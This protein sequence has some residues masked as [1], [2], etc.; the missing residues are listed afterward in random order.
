MVALR[1]RVMQAHAKRRAIGIA[2][3]KAEPAQK[4]PL[5][6]RVQLVREGHIHRPAHTSIPTLFGPLRAGGKFAWRHGGTDDLPF[7]D[8]R[9]VLRPIVLFASALVGQF[10]ARVVGNLRDSTVAF[11]PADRANGKMEYRHVSNRGFGLVGKKDRCPARGSEPPP[12]PAGRTCFAGDS[13]RCVSALRLS[14]KVSGS[15][16]VLCAWVAAYW[17]EAANVGASFAAWGNTERKSSASCGDAS[18]MSWRNNGW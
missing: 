18:V 10:G 17:C 6:F 13:P 8:I 5:R 14:S 16:E 9:F 4:L 3:L 11:G 15:S 12:P 2:Q 1:I 7:D